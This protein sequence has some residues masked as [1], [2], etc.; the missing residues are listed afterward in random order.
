MFFLNI[1]YINNSIVWKSQ[2]KCGVWNGYI[3]IYT[4]IFINDSIAP[5]VAIETTVRKSSGLQS[6]AYCVYTQEEL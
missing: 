5:K 6:D 3:T 4:D 1:Y 2:R